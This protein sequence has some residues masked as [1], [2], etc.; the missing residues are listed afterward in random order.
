MRDRNAY[1]LTI[2]SENTAG[3]RGLLAEHGWSVL[4]EYRGRRY[5]FDTGQGRVL[6]PN[7]RFLNMDIGHLDAVFLSHGHYDHS[8]ALAAVLARNPGVRLYVHPA[9]LAPKF[10]RN[11]DGTARGVGMAD[12]QREAARRANL[13]P[14][15]AA[16]EVD[17]GIFLTG[18][19]PRTSAFEDTGGAF[20]L[21]PECVRPDPL[22]DDQAA[23]FEVGDG[24]VV[25]LGCAHAG[26]I[27]TLSAIRARFG[28]RPVH[29]LIGGMHL[30]HAGE[31]RLACTIEALREFELRSLAP[32]H[33]TGLPA[34]VR[35]WNA[36]PGRCVAVK[37]GSVF[38]GPE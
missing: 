32:C 20:F 11:A 13:V 2:L 1:R 9:A 18:P 5:L 37:T 26:V 7:A 23:C 31:D 27:N 15:E 6:E 33:C 4:L 21:D 35:L 34:V 3:G 25:I 36:F 16:T 30:V 22:V 38:E 17:A 14:V 10:A 8:G 24:L 29:A 12:K 28:N 19:I